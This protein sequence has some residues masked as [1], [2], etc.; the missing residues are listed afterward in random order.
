MPDG[1]ITRRPLITVA[2]LGL[3]GCFGSS[4][5]VVTPAPRVYFVGPVNNA[6]V[7]SPLRVVLGVQD[8]TLVPACAPSQPCPKPVPGQ[9]HH[10][11][12]IDRSPFPQ[13]TA[14]PYAPNIVHYGGGQAAMDVELTPS[15]HTLT[16]QFANTK[17]EVCCAFKESIQVTVVTLQ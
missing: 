3:T 11:L 7:T 12:I 13:K 9:G 5:A 15:L 6:Y 16:A 1:R 4:T 17:H 8:L 10:H 14:I 2:F